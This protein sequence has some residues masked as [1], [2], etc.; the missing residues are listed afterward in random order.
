VVT[1]KEFL[2]ASKLYRGIYL[3]IRHPLTILFGYIFVFLWGMCLR[4]LFRSGFKHL[5]CLVAIIFHFGIGAAVWY[6]FGT[7]AFLIGFLV[8]ILISHA[9]G[10]YLFYAQ[11]N[12]PSVT[13]KKKEEWS[14]TEAALFSSSYMKLNKFMQWCTGNIGFHHIHHLNARIPFY[15]LPEVYADMPELQKVGITSLS[16]KDIYACIRLKVWDP[17]Q[18]KMIGLKEL[19][20]S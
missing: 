17:E 8:P 11:H 1:K 6:F 5:D 16:P 19:A 12:F 3:F 4:T 13:F 15:K 14:Y 7:T 2:A 9:L 18:N 10:A 20:G